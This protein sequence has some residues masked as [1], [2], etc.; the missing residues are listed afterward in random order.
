MFDQLRSALALVQPGGDETES[1]PTPN[2]TKPVTDGTGE[3]SGPHLFQCG[4]CETVYIAVDKETCSK[5]DSA[6]TRVP[7]PRR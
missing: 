1:T 5:C 6:V 3:E 2:E 4:S 7:S